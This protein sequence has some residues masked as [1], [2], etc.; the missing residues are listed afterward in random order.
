[1]TSQTAENESA[2]LKRVSVAM[3]ESCWAFSPS[4]LEG[5]HIPQRRWLLNGWVPDGYVSLLSGDGGTGKS[6]L[7]MQLATCAAVGVPFL[8]IEMAP[9]K[10]LY[11]ACEDDR[12]EMHRRQADI[13]V[14]LGQEWPDLDGQL[15]WKAV[16]GEDATLAGLDKGGRRIVS[17]ALYAN[18]RKFCRA[19]G[20]QLVIVDT[21][22]DT[23]GGLEIDRQQVTRFVRLLQDIARENDGAVI[24]VGHPSASGIREGTGIS[25]STAWRNAVRAVISFRRPTEEEGFGPCRGDLRILERMKG[26]Y[27]PTEGALHVRYHEGAFALDG[28]PEVPTMGTDIFVVKSK[29][30]S[31][32]KEALAAGREP[33]PSRNAANYAPK[34][35]LG[36]RDVRGLTRNQ[37]AAAVDRMLEKRLLR[38]AHIGSA[39]RKKQI[40][41]PASWPEMPGEIASVMDP[42]MEGRDAPE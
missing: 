11:L 20:I 13:N 16:F 28:D 17:T 12:D 36:Y 3:E 42:Q 8:G 2:I 37:L 9:R 27:A 14:S 32:L 40:L 39:S 10:V 21:L 22:A 31:A 29:V 4:T 1:M 35:L 33:S 5:V 23:F 25:G 38:I 15:F 24:L 7:A 19:K 30:E 6:L 41:V 34:M 18:L 26:N